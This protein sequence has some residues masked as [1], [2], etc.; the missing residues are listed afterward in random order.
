MANTP[1]RNV[2]VSE[3]LWRSSMR[4]AKAKGLTL[5]DVIVKALEVLNEEV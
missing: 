3:E 4:K 5:T 1:L 2:R